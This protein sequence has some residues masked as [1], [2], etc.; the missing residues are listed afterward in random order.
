MVNGTRKMQP[1]VIDVL[2]YCWAKR[3]KDYARYG[4]DGQTS[5]Y[6][7]YACLSGS[8]EK[9]NVAL[10]LIR[11]IDSF[12]LWHPTREEIVY[13]LVE[14]DYSLRDIARLT[15]ISRMTQSRIMNVLKRE[16]ILEYNQYTKLTEEQFDIVLELMES[17][18][19]LYNLWIGKQTNQAYQYRTLPQNVENENYY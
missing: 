16:P 13:Q 7:L 15:Q 18:E 14:A 6:L 12:A 3:Q 9:V 2:F 10:D 8:E 1:R 5:Y 11:N 17:L 19:R 4:I